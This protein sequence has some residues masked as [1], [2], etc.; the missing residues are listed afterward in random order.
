ML[1]SIK[2]LFTKNKPDLTFGIALR[3]QTGSY[4]LKGETDEDSSADEF[5]TESTDHV[6][7]WLNELLLSKTVSGSGYI[8]LSNAHYH[9]VQIDKPDIPEEELHSALK[10]LVKDIVPISP[11][12]MIVDYSDSPIIVAGRHKINVVCSQLSLLKKVTESFKQNQLQLNGIITDEFA[13]ANLVEK[14]ESPTLM[15][16]QQ[17]FEDVFLLIIVNGEIYLS[18][19]LR[20]FNELGSFSREQL[21]QRVCDSLSVEL[22]KSIDYFERQ[23]KQKPITK[24]QVVLPVAHE[25]FIVERLSQNT[26]VEVS[27]LKLPEVFADKRQCAASIGGIVEGQ[28]VGMINE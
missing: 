22:Q 16:C 2:D 3:R 17:P 5:F 21:E 19:R 15:L 18:R 6:S 24:I 1:A 27:S 7:D 11:D 14:S 9:S 23:L 26:L 4:A 25:E 28:L 8:V 10:W 12:D 13:F 20:G